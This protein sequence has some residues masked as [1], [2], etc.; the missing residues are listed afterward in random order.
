M[1]HQNVYDESSECVIAL[2]HK[3][4]EVACYRTETT[5]MGCAEPL[6]KWSVHPI[7]VLKLTKNEVDE[8]SILS[9]VRAVPFNRVTA[10]PVLAF[11]L[12]R[13]AV[14]QGVEPVDACAPS[15]RRAPWPNRSARIF[16]GDCRHHKGGV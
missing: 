11:A 13:V 15:V 7:S 8:S 16:F 1:S 10:T 12:E 6:L 14:W 3:V 9:D 5:L 4:A 2:Q